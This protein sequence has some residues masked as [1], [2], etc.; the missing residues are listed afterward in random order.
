MEG[1]AGEV[2]ED[3]AIAVPGLDGVNGSCLST[4]GIT[5][6]GIMEPI[7]QITIQNSFHRSTIQIIWRERLERGLVE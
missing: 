5:T 1:L 6:D 3:P 2:L 4:K 7:S